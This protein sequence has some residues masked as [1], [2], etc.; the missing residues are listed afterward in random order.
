MSELSFIK[1]LWRL[2]NKRDKKI[3]FIL[4][5]TSLLVSIIEMIGI[6][7]IMVFVSVATNFGAIQQNKY[8]QYV[9]ALLNCKQPSDF[10]VIFGLS[11][12]AF[13]AFRMLINAVHIY[14]MSKFA[15][16]RQKY[17]AT[18]LFHRFLQL[19]YKNFV[20]KSPAKINQ[21]ICSYTGQVTHILSALLSIA[22]EALTVACIYGMLF[23]VNWKM[24]LVLTLLLSVKV[25][26]IVKIFSGRI[27]AAGKLSQD[28][29]LKVSRAWSESYSNYKFLKLL[30]DE[31]KSR[32]R[33]HDAIEGKALANTVNLT[34]QALPRF[35]LE[36]IGFSML[37][38]V[39]VYVI[40]MYHNAQFIMPIVSMYALAFYRFL[41]S[42]NK[43]MMG[44]NQIQFNKHAPGPIYDFLQEDC[45]HLGHCSVSFNNEIRLEHIAFQYSEKG[46]VFSDASLVITKGQCIGF[47]GESGAGKSTI[48]DIIMGLLTP[49]KGT[50]LI[51]DVALT[52]DNLRSWRRMIGYIPQSIYLFEGSVAENVACGRPID[53]DRVIDALKKAHIY[54]FLCT[55]D[56]I[57]TFVG[58]GGIRLSGGQKQRVAI[59]R[60]L[61]DEP[62]VLVLDEATSAL[63][64]ET[65]EYI[66]NEIYDVSVNKTLIIIAHRLTTIERC[67]VVYKIER[68]CVYEESVNHRDNRAGRV[69]SR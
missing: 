50:I 9:Y 41:P 44:Y 62:P 23:V 66:M 51:D 21:I 54:D 47:V 19:D 52:H 16:M 67:D 43:I 30:S 5:L 15:N 18:R 58:E 1:I 17:F 34:W 28:F 14:Y 11:L 4:F 20:S 49:D 68:G 37:I 7:A 48:A 22:S 42:V 69:V 13:Y 12:L 61:Y 8:F 53:E 25:F 36:T 65:E 10:V 64:N 2:L 45:E 27:R 32:D 46:K 63:D 38:G 26:A 33:F 6:S 55:K 39:I 57:Y 56:G 29:D 40:F 60:A 24:T 59:A 31:K 35:V 3:I